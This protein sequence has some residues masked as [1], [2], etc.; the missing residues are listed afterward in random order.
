MGWWWKSKS[1][2]RQHSHFPSLKLTGSPLEIHGW[3]M[4]FPFGCR[5]RLFSVATLLLVA[6]SISWWRWESSPQIPF[7]NFLGAETQLRSLGEGLAL[8]AAGTYPAGQLRWRDGWG[9]KLGSWDRIDKG[10][11]LKM[12]VYGEIYIYIYVCVCFL[13]TIHTFYI[14]ICTVCMFMQIHF[15]NYCCW[16]A[17][18]FT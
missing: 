9:G 6:G 17:C 16:C 5:L 1:V 3:K 11:V 12:Y 13:F 8:F 7:L 18:L 15:C 10:D 4:I 2:W 14:D